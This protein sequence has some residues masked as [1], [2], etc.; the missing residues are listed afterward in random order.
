MSNTFTLH[1][2]VAPDQVQLLK[3]AGYQLCISKKVNNDYC[4][5][6]QGSAFNAVNTFQWVEQYQVFASNTFENGALVQAT[7]A[8][9]AIAFGQTA[10]LDNTGT[11]QSATGPVTG[12]SFSVDNEYQP[13]NFG[14]NQQINGKFLPIYVDKTLTVLGDETFIPITSVLAFFSKEL[15][16]SSMYAKA[17]SSSC[18]VT[19]MGTTTNTI[20]YTDSGSNGNGI[21]VAGT[22][23]SGFTAVVPRSWTPGKGFTTLPL[24]FDAFAIAKLINKFTDSQTAPGGGLGDSK[25]GQIA[26]TSCPITAIMSFQNRTFL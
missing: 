6:W 26:S 25:G 2:N 9:V 10:I 3:T 14:V 8:P 18:E 23:S 20:S 5:V 24:A 19:Y 17:T 12:G 15:T 21:W 11:M 13:V 7:S 16:T 1:V 22:A 4:V